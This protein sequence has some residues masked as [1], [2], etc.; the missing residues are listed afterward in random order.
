MRRGKAIG[1][2][3]PPV[4]PGRKSEDAESGATCRGH[5]FGHREEHTCALTMD[6]HAAHMDYGDRFRVLFG[7]GI[8][9]P[10]GTIQGGR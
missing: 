3:F 1:T 9:V 6:P 2:G 4:D 7:D 10:N 5:D 8:S